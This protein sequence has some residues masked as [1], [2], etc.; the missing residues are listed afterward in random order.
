MDDVVIVY[1]FTRSPRE[2]LSRGF[3]SEPLAR[4]AG[5]GVILYP[6]ENRSR[7]VHVSRSDPVKVVVSPIA[8]CN[9][10]RLAFLTSTLSL[11]FCTEGEPECKGQLYLTVPA[12]DT[13]LVEMSV[14]ADPWQAKVIADRL[15]DSE[16]FRDRETSEWPL[17]RPL[18]YVNAKGLRYS[19]DCRSIT[20]V[21]YGRGPFREKAVTLRAGAVND[22]K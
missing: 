7:L 9:D 4:F 3:S 21:P 12:S 17:S 2:N 11:H 10:D 15:I 19:E 20:I 16:Q 13:H 5:K 6:L 14:P 22:T 18:P 8:W 1:D